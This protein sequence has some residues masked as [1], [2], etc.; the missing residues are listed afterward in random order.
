[1][2]KI[3]ILS[4]FLWIPSAS[5]GLTLTNI[6]SEVRLIVKD[7]N[8]NREQYAD[9]DLNDIINQWQREAATL[10]YAIINSTAFTLIGN[11]THYTLPSNFIAIR[12]AVEDFTLLD[13]TSPEALDSEFSRTDWLTQRGTPDRYYQLLSQADSVSVFPWPDPTVVTATGTLT[14]YYYGL[15]ADLSSD[16]DT[17]FD[18]LVKY[19]PYHDLLVW[20][21]S[22][23]ILLIKGDVTRA[24]VYKN[25]YQERLQVLIERANEQPFY[26]PSFSG[27]RTGSGR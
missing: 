25:M 13:A 10:S 5:H 2:K 15:P 18:S 21:T 24:D 6:R 1:M 17:P 8:S 11:T 4:L 19:N 12:R 14:V 7:A 27:Q 26:R 20:Y 23:R 3:L 22:Y 16:S 9:S